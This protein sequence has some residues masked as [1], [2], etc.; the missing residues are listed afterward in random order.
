MG[1]FSKGTLYSFTH[2]TERINTQLKTFD[3]IPHAAYSPDSL[4]TTGNSI[5]IENANTLIRS[6]RLVRLIR[7]SDS[8]IKPVSNMLRFLT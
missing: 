7:Y 5:Y 2:F 6:L 1:L 8:L 4:T 3:H